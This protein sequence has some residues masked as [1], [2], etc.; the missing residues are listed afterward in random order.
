MSAL[1]LPSR[2][3]PHN[4]DAERAV[5]GG[6]LLEG[7]E[8]LPRVVEVLRPLDFY[9]EAHRTIYDAMLRL[10]ERGEPVDL[11]TLNE[12]LRR[13]DQLAAV[14]GPAATAQL[15]EEA[16]IAVH[17]MSYAAIVRDMAVLRELIQTST[18]IIGDAFEA[19]QDVQSL[20]DE[21]ERRIF[22]LAERRLE[23]SAVPV[24]QVLRNTFEY[25]ERLY[26]R[27]EHVTGVATGLTKLDELTAGLQPSDLILIAGRQS[28]G[29]TALALS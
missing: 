25:I 13:I 28:A 3:P 8:T 15:T 16:A 1:E 19:K 9:T 21:A 24:K 26:E 6:I 23:G 20:V 18:Q 7:R 2:I 12:D 17:L 4:L 29:K 10:F 22:G 27:Q 5:L 14:G 11:I